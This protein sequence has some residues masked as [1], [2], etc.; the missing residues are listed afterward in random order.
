MSVFAGPG[1]SCCGY[2]AGRLCGRCGMMC[3]GVRCHA[4]TL[5]AA[6]CAA[7]VAAWLAAACSGVV[8]V[9]VAAAAPPA[10]AAA[11]SSAL[12]PSL[13]P[14]KFG[15]GQI[16]VGYTDHSRLVRLPGRG[17]RPRPLATI[18]RYPAVGSVSRVDVRGARPAKA[19]GPY[20]L[21]VFGHGFA[22]TPTIY[23]QLLQAWAGAGYVV[24]AP[25]FPLANANAPGG[26]NESDLVNQPGDMS[27]VITRVLAGNAAP[28][29]ILSR[30]VDARR[31]AVAGQ[32]DGGSTALATAYNVHFRDRRI[33]AAVVLS[34]ARIPGVGGYDFPPPSPPLLAA[35]GTAD[36]SN[37]PKSTY[38]Y[39]GLAPSP[40]FLLSLWGA[41][42]LGP[43]T[44]QQ[45]Q[46]GVVERTSI[47]FLDRYLK[48][49]P[50]AAARMSRA[51]NV[52]GLATLIAG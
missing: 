28:S 38:T 9:R 34:G 47:A 33:G 26:P 41:P 3:H 19:G 46:L 6:V 16:V 40:K 10:H 22:V 15:V 51:G 4:V 11:G 8:G 17:L 29:G 12:A 1:E 48:R 44:R 24:A 21:I 36:R 49:L 37:A 14:A 7:V 35:Q 25:Y 23:A 2:G 31:I 52:R 45:P 42:H 30:L 32:S 50:G 20:P 43:Y 13:V 39:F 5:R 27:Y 18:I